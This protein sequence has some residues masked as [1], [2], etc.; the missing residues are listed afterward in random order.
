MKFNPKKRSV[1]GIPLATAFCLLFLTTSI[2]VADEL[3]DLKAELEGVVKQIALIDTKMRALKDTTGYGKLMHEFTTLVNKKEELVAKQEALAGEKLQGPYWYNQGNRHLKAGSYSDA[4][5]AYLK[6]VGYEP[7]NAQFY[8]NLGLAYQFNR[9][10][11]YALEAYKSAINNNANY[12]NA[13][14]AAGNIQVSL[15]QYD[16]ALTNYQ[17]AIG[18]EPANAKAHHG[19]GNVY[20]K[21]RKFADAAVAFQK[22]VDANSNAGDS[23]VNLG[24]ALHEQKKNKAAI[25]ALEKGMKLKLKNSYKQQ[26]YYYL[27]AALNAQ[28]QHTKAINAAENAIKLK[29]T[30]AAAWYE[31]GFALMKL[32]K[33]QGAVAA[34]DESRKD[35][36]WKAISDAQIKIC[37][38]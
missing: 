25:T 8:Y 3:A 38:Q 1:M 20:L 27:A 23:W 31:K 16:E 19:A 22:A 7:A 17:T 33:K 18:L 11:T 5:D 15:R 37:K 29:A 2:L 32:G 36:A 30:Y 13:F 35:A 9:Q 14:V 10:K 34:F 12:T 4:I 21:R 24:R 28:G 6:A 26:G